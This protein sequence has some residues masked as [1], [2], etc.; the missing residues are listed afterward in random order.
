MAQSKNFK[1]LR[2]ERDRNK[3]INFFAPTSLSHFLKSLWKPSILVNRNQLRDSKETFFFSLSLCRTCSVMNQ[4]LVL[5]GRCQPQKLVV[6]RILN[7]SMLFMVPPI[8]G[9]QGQ[10]PRKIQGG[11][12]PHPQPTSQDTRIP[13]SRQKTVVSSQPI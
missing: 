11:E 8:S 4:C 12:A 1:L 5:R 2:G 10:K 9:G 6:K 3:N 7:F 13:A